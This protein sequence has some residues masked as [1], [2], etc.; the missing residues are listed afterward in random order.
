MEAADEFFISDPHSGDVS[1]SLSGASAAL[2]P[3]SARFSAERS[4]CAASL[5]ASPVFLRLEADFSPQLASRKRR[6]R[7][8]VEGG[9]DQK[10]D[11]LADGETAKRTQK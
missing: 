10:S 2:Q 1:G 11:T 5:A 3:A 7:S 6:G 4:R 9:G 8:E